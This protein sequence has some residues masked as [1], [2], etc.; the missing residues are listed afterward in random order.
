LIS[1]LGNINILE[2]AST[3]HHSKLPLVEVLEAGL[4]TNPCN[5]EWA[6]ILLDS[7]IKRQCVA[8][9]EKDGNIPAIG[10]FD[11]WPY[12]EINPGM[13]YPRR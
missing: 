3:A 8:V 13:L 6:I 5:T 11:A 2:A 10:V 7:S 12:I 4:L 1:S 9:E